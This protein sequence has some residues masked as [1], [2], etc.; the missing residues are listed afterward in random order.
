MNVHSGFTTFQIELI[1]SVRRIMDIGK[2][3]ENF[4]ENS[5][6]TITSPLVSDSI[7][8]VIYQR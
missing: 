1:Y 8:R 3:R 7:N 6:I 2:I 5:T 4:P